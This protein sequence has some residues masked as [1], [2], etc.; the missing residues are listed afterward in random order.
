MITQVKCLLI[1]IRV[2]PRLI[3][4]KGNTLILIRMCGCYKQIL[5][6]GNLERDNTHAYV[7]SHSH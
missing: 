3:M 1:Q 2:D 7:H 6:E 4:Q 5:M